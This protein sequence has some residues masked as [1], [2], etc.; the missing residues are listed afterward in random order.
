[1]INLIIQVIIALLIAGF[2][3]AIWLKLKPL[4]ASIV[5]EPFLT[6]IDILIWIL[7][8]AIILFVIIIPLLHELPR[9][10]HL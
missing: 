2:V 5:A 10:I 7:V 8:A 6:I 1:M 9:Y 3:Y 4:L